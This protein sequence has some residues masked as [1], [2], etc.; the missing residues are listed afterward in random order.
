MFN[1][2]LKVYFTVFLYID[3]NILLA[4]CDLDKFDNFYILLTKFTVKF[5]NQVNSLRCQ[6]GEFYLS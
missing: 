1:K 3:K 2:S 6:A 4:N 5:V